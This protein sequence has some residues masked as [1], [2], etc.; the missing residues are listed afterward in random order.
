MSKP[1]RRYCSQRAPLRAFAPPQPCI[2]VNRGL[3]VFLS[4]LRFTWINRIRVDEQGQE[5]AWVC[6]VSKQKYHHGA[7]SELLVLVSPEFEKNDMGCILLGCS[8][9]EIEG[10][11]LGEG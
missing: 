10:M 1:P 7:I 9:P 6:C 5:A 4:A 3:G 8:K 11:R 2:R